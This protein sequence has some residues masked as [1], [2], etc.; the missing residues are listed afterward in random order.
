[1]TAD[2]VRQALHNLRQR[3][4]P[5]HGGRAFAD[6]YDSGLPDADAL[7][8]EVLSSFASTDGVDVNAYPSLLRMEQELVALAADLLDAPA[9]SVGT[10]TSGGTESTLLAVRAARDSRPE[11]SRPT[12]VLPTSAAPAFHR[13]AHTLRVEPIFVAVDPQSGRAD[14]AAM[15]AAILDSTV[16]VAASAPSFPH[17]VIDPITEIAAAAAARGVR[18]HVDAGVGGWLLPYLTRTLPPYSFAVR[19]VTSMSVNLHSYAYTPKGASILLHAS[20]ELRRPQLFATAAWPGAPLVSSTI[21][22]TKS[23]GALAAAW[24]VT[25]FIGDNGYARLAALVDQGTD[26]LL[27]GLA[28]ISHI[29]VL[30]PPDASQLAVATDGACDAFTICDE[31]A[32]RGWHV[33]PQL[34]FEGFPA[35][36]HLTLS[37]ATVPRVPEFLDAFKSSVKTAIGAG[38][39]QLAPELIAAIRTVDLRALD[40][41]TFDDLLARAGV[42]GFVGLPDRMAPVNALLDAASPPVRQAMLTGFLDRLARP[43]R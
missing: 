13:A 41:G 24:A 34:S 2:A 36:I 17:G 20:A 21:S 25:R 38:P 39:V 18:C 30:F 29:R 16:L 12:M 19:G 15:A 42:E 27:D 7:G 23:G 11:L 3:D 33:R 10:F 6:G 37:A 9:G 22:S 31:L 4:L 40:E 32:S 5:S 35:T 14:A 43:R 8:R 26:T 28:R 1:M